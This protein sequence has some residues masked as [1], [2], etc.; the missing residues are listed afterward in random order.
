VPEASILLALTSAAAR[1][2]EVELF[3]SEIGD[4]ALVYHAQRSYYEALLRAGVRIFLYEA[5]AVLHAKHFSIDE[6]V[7]VVGSS[8]MDIRSFSLN[9]EVSMMVHGRGFVDELRKVEDD[10]RSRSTE[11]LLEDWLKRPARQRVRDNL[12]RLT[13][14]IQ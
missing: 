7:A 3:A 1:G 6:D 12:A 13:S 4:Q 2:L 14:A 10:Y 8:N 5:P 9:M 11:V